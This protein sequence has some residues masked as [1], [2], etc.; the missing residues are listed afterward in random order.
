MPCALLEDS[1]EYKHPCALKQS[2]DLLLTKGNMSG[3]DIINL[4]AEHKF[5]I[6]ANAI[7]E[8]LNLEAGTLSQTQKIEN[9]IIEFP[10]K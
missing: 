5:S 4:F 3:E 8:L 6:S 2:I 1:I 10:S 9:K 7:E